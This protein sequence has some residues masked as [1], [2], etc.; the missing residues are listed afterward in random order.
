MHNNTLRFIQ[1]CIDGRQDTL[2]SNSE[3]R[4][5]IALE[6]IYP[7]KI[8]RYASDYPPVRRNSGFIK[9]TDGVE[10]EK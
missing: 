10:D 1:E 2:S 9:S 3:R 8:Y 7:K 5:Y 4:H 6:Q